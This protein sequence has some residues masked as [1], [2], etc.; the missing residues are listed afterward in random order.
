MLKTLPQI[1]VIFLKD[2]RIYELKDFEE[3][4]EQKIRCI[5]MNHCNM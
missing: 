3:K 4:W 5:F 2:S 1:D